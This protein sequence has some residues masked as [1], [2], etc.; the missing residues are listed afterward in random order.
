[1]NQLY[2]KSETQLTLFMRAKVSSMHTLEISPSNHNLEDRII[3]S[4]RSALVNKAMVGLTLSFQYMLL[5]T[6]AI[7]CLRTI[8]TAEP[9]LPPQ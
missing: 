7:C 6:F 2:C 9:M 4:A 8:F 5:A 3:N 1:M